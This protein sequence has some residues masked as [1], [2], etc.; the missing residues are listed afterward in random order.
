MDEVISTAIER[1]EQD[2]IIFL[3]EI[4]KV[5]GKSMGQ[6]PDISREGRAKRHT[7]YSR[8]QHSRY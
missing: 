2:G 1:A 4:D 8:R 6:G 7:A 5:A 3:D